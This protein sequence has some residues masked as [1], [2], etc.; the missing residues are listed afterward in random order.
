MG[1]TTTAPWNS[2]INNEEYFK[3]KLEG[4]KPFVHKEVKTNTNNTGLLRCC[5]DT[6]ASKST[7][8][9]DYQYC[10]GENTPD[11]DSFSKLPNAFEADAAYENVVKCVQWTEHTS[12]TTNKTDSVEY[13]FATFWG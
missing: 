5:I 12:H 13:D 10:H 8:K 1:H 6:I 7:T 11:F 3:W 2:F 4:S 9:N